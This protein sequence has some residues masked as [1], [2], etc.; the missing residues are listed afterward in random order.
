M[1]YL[2]SSAGGLGVRNWRV[3]VGSLILAL[4]V[5]ALVGVA[6]ETAGK[7]PPQPEI[8]GVVI[9]DGVLQPVADAEVSLIRL[10]SEGPRIIS[11]AIPKD[12]IQTTKTGATGTF[13]F[14]VEKMGDYDVSVQKEGYLPAPSSRTNITLSVSAEH[15]EYDVKFLVIR[16]AELS[17]RV[18]DDETGEPVPMLRVFVAQRRYFRGRV[19]QAGGAGG[20]A[21]TDAEGRFVVGAL[22]PGEYALRLGSRLYGQGEAQIFPERAKYGSAR[23]LTDF[24]EDDL[25]AVTWDCEDT[26]WPG[27]GGLQA[28]SPIPLPSGATMNVGKIPAKKRRVYSARV[29]VLA[30]TCATNTVVQVEVRGGWSSTTAAR[31]PC[32]KDFLVRGLPPGSYRIE[33]VAEGGNRNTRERGS[34]PFDIVDESIKVSVPVIRGVDVDGRVV[35]AEGAST[36]DLKKLDLRLAPVGW[37]NNVDEVFNKVDGEGRFRMVNVSVRDHQLFVSGVTNPH[38]VKEVR[39]NGFPVPDN[40]VPLDGRAPSHSL[41]I[42]VDDKPAAIMGT[43]TVSDRPVNQPHVVLVKWPLNANDPYLFGMRTANGDKDGKFQFVGLPPGEYRIFAVDAADRAR[44]DEPGVLDRT[45]GGAQK[46]T[47]SERGFQ[48]VKLELTE[49]R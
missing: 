33:A 1:R 28:V 49:T 2:L 48:N 43:V 34:V 31:V 40:V 24:S 14:K 32:G 30:S 9:E 16:P 22:P 27:G 17:G 25:N 46:V 38:Y 36:P 37:V 8:R 15:P 10:P 29:S 23:L 6:Q 3:C 41:E 12:V 18:V 39:Y 35:L 47:L 13:V 4:C 26:W 5:A 44:L 42:V 20:S 7:K 19:T 45:L 21:T 11:S